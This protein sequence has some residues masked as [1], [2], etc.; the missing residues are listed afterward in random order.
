V[1]I[2]YKPSNVA[3]AYNATITFTS[4][5]VANLNFRSSL[6]QGDWIYQAKGHGILPTVMESTT[7]IGALG[8]LTR[9][10]LVFT[11]PLEEPIDLK[12][13]FEYEK[14]EDS[15]GLA[16]LD[17]IDNS[18]S[19]TVEISIPPLDSMQIPFSFFP[20]TMHKQYTGTIQV[21][22]KKNP[23]FTWSYPIVG[24]PQVNEVTMDYQPI[25]LHCKSRTRTKKTVQLR[26][27]ELSLL[28]DEDIGVVVPELLIPKQFSGYAM[29]L[30]RAL[31]IDLIKTSLNENSEPVVDLDVAFTPL[32]SMK[33][34]ADLILHKQN[35]GQWIFPIN[36]ESEEPDIDDTITVEA[37]KDQ[38]TGVA[39]KVVNQFDYQ[40]NFTAFFV[41]DGPGGEFTVSPKSGVMPLSTEVKLI[42]AKSYFSVT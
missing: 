25:T 4:N 2:I 34:T 31:S 24:I 35:G 40:A 16:L 21:V 36:L 9:N 33:I 3:D 29:A 6:N 1:Q 19:D 41:K 10:D 23:K 8:Q 20:Q 5:K 14:K 26:L 32:R 15:N 30:E 7:V 28:S 39:F 27:S 42:I 37:D 18:Q 17:I 11:N 38:S 12:V 22:D 13:E